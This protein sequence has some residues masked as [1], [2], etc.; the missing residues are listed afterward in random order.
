MARYEV[1]VVEPHARNRMRLGT[2]LAG[3]AQFE[4]IDELVQHLRPGRPMVAVF[5]PS[6]AV[7]Y[8]FQQVQR[9]NA[10]YPQLG[11][12]FAVD[13]VSADTLQA[14]IRAGARD[15]VAV[16]DPVALDQAVGRVGD[17]LAGMPSSSVPAVSGHRAAPGRLIV[18]FSTKGGVGK[19]TLAINLAVT[20]ARKSPERVALVDADVNFGDVAV[21]LGIP[22][23][24]TV[25][26]AVASLQLGD[27]ELIRGLMTRHQSGCLVLPAPT[28]PML[29]APMPGDELVAVCTALQAMC[30]YVVVDTPT[31]FDD[32]VLALVEAA[33]DVLLVG[34]MDIPSVKNL[35]IGM[36]AL[37]LAGIAGPKMRLVLNRAN[38]QV[39]LD[40]REI[41]QV[42]GMRADFPI[43]SDVAVPIAVNAGVPVVEQEP[44]A[45]VTRAIEQI[46]SQLMVHA[47]AEETGKRRRRKRARA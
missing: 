2:H 24:H 45:A 32:S 5:G 25:A 12:V 39:K 33:D 18:V 34:S 40:V 20:L 3:A 37:D 23:Q 21:M 15:T 10:T 14:A 46:A 29:G 35:K 47:P 42:L 41:E 27:V 16:S 6:L 8:G 9:L 22:P 30:G 36:R 38:T 4:S 28:E 31:Q 19:S 44:K 1:A 17:L 13:E 43:P 7:P 11:A 26:D